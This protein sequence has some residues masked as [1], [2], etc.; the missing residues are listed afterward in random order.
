MEKDRAVTGAKKSGVPCAGME[1]HHTRG[2][3]QQRSE[4]SQR[5]SID[6]LLQDFLEK[7]SEGKKPHNNK[8]NKN[9]KTNNTAHFVGSPSLVF[10][11]WRRALEGKW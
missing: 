7:D 11:L 10:T 9:K 4:H 8:T 3:D 5:S 2:E 6:L 1:T